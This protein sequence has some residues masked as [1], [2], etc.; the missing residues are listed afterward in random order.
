MAGR[1]PQSF[2]DDLIARVDIVE[3]IDARVPLKKKGHEYQACCPFHNEKTPSFTVSPTK[4]F[5]HCFGCG[6]HGTALG[7]L[8]EYEHMAFPEAV[9]ALAH[10][11][12]LDIPYEQGSAPGPGAAKQKSEANTLFELL[13]AVDAYYQQ[14]LRKHP[15]ASTAVDYLKQRGLSGEIAKE[16]G[17]GF[18]PPGYDNLLQGLPSQ[19]DLEANLIKTGMRILRDESNQ[20]ANKSRSYDRF[21]NRIMFPIRDQRGRPIAFGGR[22]LEGDDAQGRANAAGGRT[23]GA[24]MPK[25]LNSPETPLFHKGREL[26]GLYECRKALRNIDKILV[27]EGYMDVV[28][29]AQFGVR[30]AVATLG[31]ATTADHVQKLFRLTATIIFCFDGDRAGRDAAWRALDNVMSVMREG[32]QVK[33]MFLPDG[34]DPDSYIRQHGKDVFEAEMDKSQTLT[35]FFLTQ[36]GTKTELGSPEGSARLVKLAQPYINKLQPGIYKQMLVSQLADFVRFE[37]DEIAQALGAVSAPTG[38]PARAKK[39]PHAPPSQ[40]RTALTRL[41]YQ[42]ALAQTFQDLSVLKQAELPGMTLLC[43]VLELLHAHPN[44]TCAGILEKLRDQEQASHLAK[45]AHWQPELEDAQL[46]DEFAGA[47][48]A[49]LQLTREQRLDAL[50]VKSSHAQL[51][52]EEKRELQQLTQRTGV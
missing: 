12:G 18:A 9:E 1:I 33:F 46:G 43:T 42:P 49:L 8:M 44:L 29:L 38:K 11:Q 16:Y 51:T 10:A 22:I 5:Y 2:I 26:Y 6:A 3:V 19:P 47:M 48:N 41:L 13:H 24:A 23:P 20:Q 39:I 17:L 50:L 28:A 15:Q 31:T 40:V 35:S 37:K 4:Q 34:E 52:D 25:Y 21:R 14:Q 30:Y 36:L 45:L 32:Y 27:V 7:F